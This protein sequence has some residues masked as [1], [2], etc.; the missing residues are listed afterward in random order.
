MT[1]AIGIDLGTTYSCVMHRLPSGADVTIESRQGGQLTP[2][3]VYFAP[4]GTV[5]VGEQAKEHLADD[6]ENLVVGIKRRMGQEFPLE[7]LGNEYTPE[8]ISGLILR[9]LAEDAAAQLGT[10]SRELA[11]VITVPAYFGAGEREATFAAARIAGLTCLELLPEPVAAAYAYGLADEPD[12]TSLVYDLGGGTF[13]VAVV[14]MHAGSPRVWAVDGDTQLGGLDWDRRIEDLLW[15]QVDM[16]DDSEDLRY[17]DDVVGSITA[18]A[19]TLKRRLT[20]QPTVTERLFLHGRTLELRVTRADFEAASADLL[21]RSAETARRAAR[22]A[23][24]MGAPEIDQVLLVG[25][26]TRMPMVRA[27]LEEQLGLPVRIADPD[28][29]VARGAAVLADQL[30]SRRSG[31]SGAASGIAQRRITSV[32]PRSL[33]VLIWSSADPLRDEPYVQHVLHANTPLPIVD[34]EHVVATI[35]DGQDRARIQIYEQAG[36]R[37]S[38]LPVDNRLLL[39]GEILGIPPAP[40]G[41]PIRLHISVSTDGRISVGSRDGARALELEV[42]AFL[43]GVLDD[44]D[45]AAQRATISG[46]RMV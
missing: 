26:S 18:A 25:G 7:Y 36:T 5:L 30:V 2:S 12:R 10:E 40:A 27:L 16:L 42:E 37:E 3:A 14:G 44:N 39:E 19:E 28:K 29:A 4:D 11:A 21:L 23:A 13:D 34:M 15:E 22:A 1:T 17:D 20:A 35:V 32:L 31:S 38:D 41:R 46:L 33:G 45:V 24:D 6:A 8:G 43:H 9:S